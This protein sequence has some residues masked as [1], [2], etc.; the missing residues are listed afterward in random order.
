MLLRE[1]ASVFGR[2]LRLTVW[3]LVREGDIS[4]SL[5]GHF[6][7][8]INVFQHIAKLWQA[9]ELNQIN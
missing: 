7:A 6:H 1:N 5:Q 2:Y 3:S 8:L 9:I 4:Y